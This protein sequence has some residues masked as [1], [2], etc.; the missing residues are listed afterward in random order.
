VMIFHMFDGEKD[1]IV[2][3]ILIFGLMAN[4]IVCLAYGLSGK[5]LL[6]KKFGVYLVGY[7]LVFFG[8]ATYFSFA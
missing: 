5:F 4:L 6:K 2:N 8:L 3:L 7:Y 1:N